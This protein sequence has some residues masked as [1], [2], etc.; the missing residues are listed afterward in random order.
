MIEQ[1]ISF[2]CFCSHAFLISSPGGHLWCSVKIGTAETSDTIGNLVL[3]I[4][5]V[6]KEESIKQWTW[7]A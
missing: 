1:V 4:H 3:Q 7:P 5:S 2:L 6:L